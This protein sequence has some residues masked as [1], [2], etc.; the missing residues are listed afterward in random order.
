MAAF[1]VTSQGLVHAAVTV[2]L[3][4]ATGSATIPALQT[5]LMVEPARRSHSPRR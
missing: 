4:S 1:S 5:R 3:I 2:F